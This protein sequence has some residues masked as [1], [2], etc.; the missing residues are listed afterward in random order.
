[1]PE[2]T[3]VSPQ[4]YDAWLEA[5][6]GADKDVADAVAVR[7]DLRAK[8][9]ASGV[10]LAAFDRSRVDAQVA[11]AVRDHEEIWYQTFMAWIGKPVPQG[12]QAA[13]NLE[14]D[15]AE[16]MAGRERRAEDEGY[17][18]GLGGRHSD[19]NTWPP[20][21]AGYANWHTGWARGHAEREAK[22]SA[23]TGTPNGGNKRPPGRPKGSRNKKSGE[24]ADATRH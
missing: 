22:S 15:E 7:K 4:Q 23:S 5:Y 21:S 19:E 2:G 3:N 24:A 16:I 1:M 11:S 12:G 10:P 18:A 8:I 9:K 14:T 6:A 13:M 20:G 17:K